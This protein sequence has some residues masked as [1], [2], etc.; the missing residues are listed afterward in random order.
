MPLPAPATLEVTEFTPPANATC[1]T[2]QA[3]TFSGTQTAVQGD[4]NTATNDITGVKCGDFTFF[5]GPQLYYSIQLEAQKEYLV[6]AETDPMGY[7]ATLYA[8]PA[9][10]ACSATAINP[11]CYYTYSSPMNPG[12]RHLVLNPTVTEDWIVVVDAYDASGGGSF[13]LRIQELTAPANDTCAAATALSFP[14]GQSYLNV[15]GQTLKATSAVNLATTDC[16]GQTTLG[17]D[18]FYQLPVKANHSYSFFLVPPDM[19]TDMALYLFTDCANVAGTCGTGMGADMGTGGSPEMLSYSPTADG[20]ILIGVDGRNA[21]DLGV[22]ALDITEI[23]P[24]PAND[25]CAG[26]ETL[27]FDGTGVATSQ[28]DLTS[29]TDTIPM[30]NCAMGMPL[31]GPELFYQVTLT[32][33]QSY[34]ITVTPDATFDPVVY[35]LSGCNIVPGTCLQAVNNAMF[36]MAETL[37]YTPTTTGSV[38]IGVDGMGGPKPPGP[39]PGL[40]GTFTIEVK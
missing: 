5:D 4:T 23:G 34:T 36:G 35:L 29:A 31:F 37:S 13:T 3:L 10:T 14:S 22:F 9:S 39:G 19:I 33:N 30:L 21:V 32:A 24:P 20:T 17:P 25:T 7:G 18:V 16:T 15:L 38:I 1:A 40:G 28:G 11:A 2:P 26:A 6:L 12:P 27:T 8:F